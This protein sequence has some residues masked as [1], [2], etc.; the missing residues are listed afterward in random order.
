VSGMWCGRL[1][2]GLEVRLERRRKVLMLMLGVLVGVWLWH[3]LIL[4]LLVHK[5]LLI[6]HPWILRVIITPWHLVLRSHRVLLM[7][8]KVHRWLTRTWRRAHHRRGI[9]RRRDASDDAHTHA[10]S[11]SRPGAGARTWARRSC[12]H[13]HSWTMRSGTA[14]RRWSAR[15]TIRHR[16][17]CKRGTPRRLLRHWAERTR[18]GIGAIRRELLSTRLLT[19]TGLLLWVLLVQ[20][21][22]VSK[23]RLHPRHVNGDLHRYIGLLW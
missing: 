22:L 12:L 14:A 6:L 11:Y 21:L 3:P 17:M 16:P 13:P 19:R 1:R 18:L 20:M 2:R 10:L 4:R 7:L 5:S 23:R 9:I 15:T 8:L